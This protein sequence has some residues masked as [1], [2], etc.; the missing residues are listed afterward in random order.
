[1]LA[2]SEGFAFWKFTLRV[3]IDLRTWFRLYINDQCTWST[4]WQRSL[5]VV[6]IRKAIIFSGHFLMSLFDFI[7]ISIEPKKHNN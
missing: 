1:M 7:F 3:L 2:A 6:S 5:L 4:F